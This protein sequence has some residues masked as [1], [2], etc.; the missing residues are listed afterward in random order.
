M[1]S[2]S[3]QRTLEAT[4]FITASGRP[5]PGLELAEDDGSPAWRTV[6]GQ[7]GVG[8]RADAVF[9]A[10]ATPVSI[11]KDAGHV[12]PSP[13]Q[14]RGWHEAAW[15][16]GSVPLLWIITPTEVRL[17]D[18]YASPSVNGVPPGAGSRPLDEF[19]I[20]SNDRL[21][22]LTATCGRLATE[23]GA[24]WS[25]EIGSRI[26]RRHRV[27]RELLAEINALEKRLT[28]SPDD[29]GPESSEVLPK[30]MA[31]RLIGRCIFT[32]YLLDRGLAQPFL[33]SG[34][35]P[36]LSEMLASRESAFRLFEFLRETFNGDLFPMDDPGSERESITEKHLELIRGFVDGQSL[37]HGQVGQGRLFRFRFNAIPIELISSIYEQ[38][39]RS[40]AAD[41]A[42]SQGLHYTPIELVHLVV[43]PVLEGLPPDARVIDPACGSGVFLVEAFRRL[44]QRS[45]MGSRAPRQLVRRI[46]RNQLFGI[47]INRS[48]LGIAAFSLYLAALELDEDPINDISDLQF[49]RLINRTLFEADSTASDLPSQLA[50]KRFH[51]VVGNPPWTFVSKGNPTIADNNKMKPFP[52]RSPDHRFLQVAGELSGN[53]GHIGMVMKATPFFSIN[54][55]AVCY[56]NEL[57]KRLAPTALINLSQLRKEKLFPSS[58]GPALLF[59]SRCDLGTDT[60]QLLVGSIPW[61]PDFQRTGIFQVGAGEIQ[62]IALRRILGSP[63][64]LKVAAFGTVRDRWLMDRLISECKSLDAVLTE[65]GIE[66][67]KHRGQGYQVGRS[68]QKP[69]PNQYFGRSVLTPT[70]FRAFRLHPEEFVAFRH[71]TLHRPRNSSIFAG[72]MVICPQ[73]GG[74]AST[75]YGRYA[76]AVYEDDLLYT[77]SF[78]GV[79]FAGI[80]PRLAY[81]IS[82]ILNSSMTTFQLMLGGPTWGLERPQ[83]KPQ[84]LLALRFPSL[85][86][87]SSKD[88]EAVVEAEGLAAGNPDNDRI[89]ALDQAVFNLY[90]LD[91]AERTLV[92]D[93]VERARFLLSERRDARQRSVVPPTHDTLLTYGRQVVQTVNAYLRALGTRHLEG[94][95]YP[96]STRGQGSALR[97]PGATA[98]RFTMEPGGP[99]QEAI[100]KVGD[101]SD[102]D[103]LATILP[104]ELGAERPPYLNERRHFRLYRADDLF[105]IKP[106]EIRCW[107]RATALNDAD[108]ILADHW[109]HRS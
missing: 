17:Y 61:S 99:S 43:D 26:D 49:D 104:T 96:E 74:K 85:Q 30:E 47:D 36:N 6:L 24:F 79:S 33:P 15:N 13:D 84:A 3:F 16:I 82:G 69:S 63:M 64:N 80:D 107:T 31:Q 46:L 105:V 37:V 58:S 44:V 59:F 108:L 86:N 66:R 72:P 62:P 92:L 101:V 52:R 12:P 34:L 100:V 75:E 38:F 98:V 45:T 51:A 4:G 29:G 55:Q 103:L 19:S 102:L 109:S 56:R 94:V 14:I 97:I 32:W 88:I 35:A 57:L 42:N 87:A 28:G 7:D 70:G 91:E 20:E 2:S 8:L 93:S 40:S 67:R 81:A 68:Q 21:Q 25:S 10:Q 83:V 11:F 50:S 78:F 73:F 41:A 76:A 48:A 60:N 27:D 106:A 89:V 65:L 39:A 71:T 5:L 77:E 90:R 18:C 53:Q 9:C 23:T 1:L 54:E 22:A 95:I